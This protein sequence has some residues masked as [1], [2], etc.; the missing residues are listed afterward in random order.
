MDSPLSDHLED[1]LSEHR[2]V[3]ALASRL[4]LVLKQAEDQLPAGVISALHGQ[5]LGHPLHPLLV[6]LPLGGWIIAGVLD[7]APLPEGED[8]QLARQHAADLAL[9]L[10]TLGA[11]GTL[12]TGWTDWS[13]TRAQARRTGLIHGLLNETAFLLNG[14]S[15]LARRKGQR[16][17]GKTLSGAALMLAVGGGFLGGQLVYRHGLGVHHTL[18]TP[19]R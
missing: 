12:A 17:L 1:A 9:L 3:E 10:G 7:F 14:A 15:L 6:H 5:F 16:K 18:A 8:A 11:L 19:Q 4:Q 13:N 2:A